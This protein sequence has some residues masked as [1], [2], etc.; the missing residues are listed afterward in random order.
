MCHGIIQSITNTSVTSRS[1]AWWWR[2]KVTVL[3]SAEAILSFEQET[4]RRPSTLI[5]R[6]ESSFTC[7]LE[8]LLLSCSVPA[9]VV[10]C[11]LKQNSSSLFWVN[12]PR[13]FCTTLIGE[14]KLPS[15]DWSRSSLSR[16]T[17]RAPSTL[18]K[19]HRALFFRI[20]LEAPWHST[21]MI[22][23]LQSFDS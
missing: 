3:P 9:S 6:S 8:L 1:Q 20:Q 4:R 12:K 23:S 13:H 2:R 22:T 15:T 7:N 11:F 17:H 5:T 19:A 16:G 14:S 21:H 10:R 18:A